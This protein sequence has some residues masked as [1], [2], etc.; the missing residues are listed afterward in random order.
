MEGVAFSL[1]HNLEVAEDAGARAGTLRAMGG[2]ANSLVWT[3]IKSDVTGCPIEVPASDT[4]TT[5][6]AALLAGVGT[7]L[8]SG[9]D[10][11]TKQTVA[12][13][14]LHQP[15][16]GNAAVYGKRYADYLA[17]AQTLAPLMAE[18]PGTEERK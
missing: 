14:R 11:A 9:F 13:R 3:Q 18:Q 8:Y 17:L 5:L 6:G 10:E 1:R 12:V 4:A 15:D 7:G 16:A 2:S